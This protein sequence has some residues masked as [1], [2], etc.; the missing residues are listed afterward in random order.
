MVPKNQF[1]Q[2][3]HLFP[4]KIRFACFKYL[5][6]HID[7]FALLVNKYLKERKKERDRTQ[8]EMKKGVY[9]S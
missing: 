3:R 6:K 7:R 9:S 4:K 5:K 8:Y 1:D 2:R